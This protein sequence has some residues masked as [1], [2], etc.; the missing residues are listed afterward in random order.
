[1]LGED[2]PSGP[3]PNRGRR[4]LIEAAVLLGFL[5]LAAAETGLRSNLATEAF[6]GPDPVID[7]WTLHWVSAHLLKDPAHLFDGNIFF[8]AHDTVLF[9]DPLIGPALLAQPLLPFTSNPILIYNLVVLLSLALTSHGLWRLTR[10]M[11]ADPLSALLPGI[12]VPYCAHQLHHLTQ[13]NLAAICG[14]PWLLLALLRLLERPGWRTAAATALAFA[15]QAGTSGYQA[16]TCVALSLTVAA[17]G[18]RALA[19]RRTIVFA[20][21]AALLAGALLAPYVLGFERLRVV[22]GLERPVEDIVTHSLSLPEDLFRTQ[23]FVWRGV[24]PGR[25]DSA[26]PGLAVL[27]LAGAAALRA[28]RPP[29]RL[30]LL[31]AAVFLLLSLGPTL[32]VRGRSV[33][34]LPY[35]FL[36]EHVPLLAAG[37]HPATFVIGTVLSLGILAG[38]GLAALRLPPLLRGVALGLALVETLAPTARRLDRGRLPEA[39]SWLNA[40]GAEA[41]AELPYDD[42]A[43]QLWAAYQG[44]CTTGGVSPY[45]PVEHLEMAQRIRHEWKREP[46]RDLEGTPS[47]ALFKQRMPVTHL[48]LNPNRPPAFVRNVEATPATFTFVYQTREGARIYRVRRGGSGSRIRRVFRDDQLRGA[49]L[50]VELRAPADVPVRVRLNGTELARTTGRLTVLRALVP[51]RLLRRGANEVEITALDG[52]TTVELAD[53][54][55]VPE[56]SASTCR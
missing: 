14:L 23:A 36:H 51:D 20:L 17:W 46:A 12:A 1:V 45:S 48:L 25:G 37:R 18:F 13:L 41:V 6:A 16:F 4:A 31:L 7:I 19:R 28:R 35:G 8:P 32:V 3:A 27:L 15:W 56:A 33:M 54:G 52:A 21:L 24:L 53:V 26:F 39:Y 5:A 10:A 11:G 44:L 2:I 47:L 22:D 50:Q 34:P 38:L 40:H 49:I 55:V 9:S 42:D 43:P 29:V 30:L